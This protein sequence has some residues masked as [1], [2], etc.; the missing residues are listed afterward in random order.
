MGKLRSP[1]RDAG[2]LALTGALT[3]PSSVPGPLLPAPD[4]MQTP[5]LAMVAPGGCQWWEKVSISPSGKAGGKPLEAGCG[6][7]VV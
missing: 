6:A 5:V 2:E 7:G 1:I 4:P 3:Q